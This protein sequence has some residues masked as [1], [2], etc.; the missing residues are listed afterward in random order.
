MQKVQLAPEQVRIHVEFLIV[1]FV[2]CLKRV[3]CNRSFLH[4]NCD[5]AVMNAM[6]QAL[7]SPP[8]MRILLC[9][10]TFKGVN[11]VVIKYPF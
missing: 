2:L 8:G 7:P 5:I 1:R 4:F 9:M 11:K 6:Q 3:Y 10:I